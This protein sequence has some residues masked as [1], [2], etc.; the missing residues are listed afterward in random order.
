MGKKVF[1]ILWIFSVV[2]GCGDK[3]EED[4]LLE[5]ESSQIMGFTGPGCRM[6]QFSSSSAWEI[7]LRGEGKQVADWVSLSRK[8]GD[9]GKVRVLV[10]VKKGNREKESRVA[11]LNLRGSGESEKRI[12]VAQSEGPE[13]NK[14]VSGIRMYADT[15]ETGK[16]EFI[17]DEDSV[18]YQVKVSRKDRET[19][20][21]RKGR[22]L[23]FTVYVDRI[24]EI[25]AEYEYAWITDGISGS[26]FPIVCQ[27]T[28]RKY[29][30]PVSSPEGQAGEFIYDHE[31]Q[32]KEI[33]ARKPGEPAV[34]Y[35]WKGNNLVMIRK[36]E[37][38]YRFSY[39]AA[40]SQ[41]NDLNIDLFY[42]IL[43]GLCGWEEFSAFFQLTGARPVS[44]PEKIIQGDKVWRVDYEKNAAR[45]ITAICFTDEAN[46]KQT[47]WV[48]NYD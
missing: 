21:S 12:V 15:E 43:N 30:F 17:Y 8:K 29:C 25:H 26:C 28:G 47:Q 3:E 39:P 42:I 31:T 13:G 45:Y 37:E 24:P 34:C 48:M 16:F 40:L 41:R 32:L 2:V 1:F 38:E 5:L 18:C 9:A 14:V 19:V 6:L 10:E 22:Q 35:T 20:I 33:K 11:V 44:L 46:G 36:G 4:A 23:K 7:E 27:Y